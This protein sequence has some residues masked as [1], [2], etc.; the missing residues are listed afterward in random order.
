[1]QI[2]PRPPLN[3]QNLRL[4][5]VAFI[6]VH[7]LYVGLIISGLLRPPPSFTPVEASSPLPL[8]LSVIAVFNLF[9]AH[10]LRYKKYFKPKAAGQLPS[11]SRLNRY[12]NA[13]L[14]AFV[15][16]MSSSLFGLLIAFYTATPRYILPFVALGLLCH[17]T[18]M[19]KQAHL[20]D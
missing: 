20:D 13:T 1:M 12:A 15:L 3:L 11:E 16:A 7:L 17:L 5:W 2:S 6:V 9:L 10:G 8:S 4:A 18:L 19:P 14:L